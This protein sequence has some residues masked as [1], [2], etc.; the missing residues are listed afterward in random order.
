[1][2]KHLPVI[3][4]AVIFA[5]FFSAHSAFAAGW[6][7]FT[8]PTTS[9]LNG[10]DCGSASTCIAVGDSGTVVYTTNKITWTAGVSGTTETLRDV[11]MTSSTVG[12]AVGAAGTILKTTDGGATWSAKTSGTTEGLYGVVMVS[13]STGWAV[14]SD[15]AIRKTTDGGTTWSNA[16]AATSA[17]FRAVDA[18]STS[19]VWAAGR[20]G[21]VYRSTNGGSTWTD[22]S[23]ISAQEID[24]I[25]ALSS[26]NAV[27]G[28]TNG[29]AEKTTNSGATWT[30][31]GTITGFSSTETVVDLSFWTV[32][33]G[34]ASGSE[35]S[36]ASTSDTAATWTADT[37]V[38]STTPVI[39]DS[40]T[41]SVGVRYVV[42][43][44]GF[45]GFYDNYGPNMPTDLTVDGDVT[46]DDYV[47]STT[48]TLTWTAATDDEG[49]SVTYEYNLDSAGY[50]ASGNRTSYTFSALAE[51]SHTVEVRA[52]DSADNE[53]DVAT[54]IFMVDTTAPIVGAV[55]PSTATT[56]TS[57]L[58][59]V[60]AD[61]STSDVDVCTLYRGTTAVASMTGSG[62]TWSATVTTSTA[63][64]YSMYATCVDLAGNST[65]GASST[66]VVSGTSSSDTTAPTVGSVTPLVAVQNTA[67]TLSATYSDSVG[68]SSCTM[69]VNGGIVGS[70]TLSSGTARKTYTFISSGTNTAYATCVDAAGNVGIGTTK[71][72]VVSASSSTETD[73]A[74][75]EALPGSLIKLAC[76]A[77]ADVNDPCKA[78]YYFGDDGKRHAFP[79]E[80]VYFTWYTDFDDV[81]IVTDDYMASLMLGKNV[82]YH[83]GTK[84]VKFITVNTV[85]AVGEDGKLRAIGSEEI[86][87][88]IYGSTWNKKIDDISD[89]FFGNYKFGD[90]IDSTSD[91]DPDVVEESVDSI[92]DIL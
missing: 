73:E 59:V 22:V 89:A 44:A 81:I 10:V 84:M 28:G 83:P 31:F 67:L 72:I 68:V 90:A 15:G 13:T 51:G 79:N 25:D 35:G 7:E 32:S 16:S 64:T 2:R 30:S 61:D 66:L 55:T 53:G 56:G 24:T 65:T 5:T 48:P 49:S 18:T 50:I 47:S 33:S 38:F 20:F 14:G 34:N 6:T 58:F 69:Y 8:S 27:I 71:A 80:K 74:V 82:T 43:E 52:V 91:F 36:L 45:V 19:I 12:I 3:V 78:V 85:Y 29:L 63:G 70:M 92:D 57:T 17:D 11:D 86:A 54:L 41:P 88:S 26:S 21:A 46:D 37:N 77:G 87:A 4:G 76:D 60:Y 62:P 40:A 75:D 1:M 9:N 23:S 39:A 42:G